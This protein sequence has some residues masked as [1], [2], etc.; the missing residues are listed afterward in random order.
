MNKDLDIRSHL[1]Q[2]SSAPVV[3]LEP[4]QLVSRALEILSEEL[5]NWKSLEVGGSASTTATDEGGS[6]RPEEEG[7]K[8]A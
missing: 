8:E 3:E 6:L 4:D 5:S 1:L 2:G 7:Q